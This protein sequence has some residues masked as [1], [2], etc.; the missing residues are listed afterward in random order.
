VAHLI[1]GRGWTRPPAVLAVASVTFLLA[2]PSALSSGAVPYLSALPGVGMDF[3]SL[4]AT[5]WNNYSLPIGGFLTAIFVG[6]VWRV[7]HALEELLAH[8][9]SFPAAPLWG[10][11][12]RWIC[13]AAIALIII[14]TAAGL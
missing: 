4:M 5:V 2:I 6:H 10:F 14:A 12:I 7:D 13:P 1:D 9:A 3:L 11:L 8:H